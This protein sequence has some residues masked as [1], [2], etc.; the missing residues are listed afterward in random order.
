MTRPDP[1]SPSNLPINVNCPPDQILSTLKQFSS[2]LTN[3][4]SE[5]RQFSCS[6][7]T[8]H[9]NFKSFLEAKLN[10]LNIISESYSNNVRNENGNYQGQGLQVGQSQKSGQNDNFSQSIQKQKDICS[11]TLTTL[12]TT[13]YRA[14]IQRSENYLNMFSPAIS[15]IRE[16]IEMLNLEQKQMNFQSQQNQNFTDQN[17]VNMVENLSS[18]ATLKKRNKSADRLS[19][20]YKEG[21]AGS[22]KRNRQRHSFR[23]ERGRDSGRKGKNLIRNAKLRE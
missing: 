3:Q 5:A 22:F 17:N 15:N 2:N 13:S 19:S 16:A 12:R 18:N 4:S 10:L 7:S 14:L 1:T 11:K 9:N 8:Y 23:Y 20:S 21:E 6:L